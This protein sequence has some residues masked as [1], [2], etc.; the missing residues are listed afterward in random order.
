MTFDGTITLGNILTA[1]VFLF[2]LWGAVS[3]AY[4]L[5]D[6]RTTMFEGTLTEHANLLKEHAARMVR[7]EEHMEKQDN[8]LLHISGDMQRIVG[9]FEAI[10]THGVADAAAAAEALVLSVLA[11]AAAAAK[12]GKE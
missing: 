3:R 4:H 2:G 5:L 1:V 10:N 9:R 11:A 12:A 7:Q 8:I 6:K